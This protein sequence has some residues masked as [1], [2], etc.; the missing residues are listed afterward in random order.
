MSALKHVLSVWILCFSISLGASAQSAVTVVSTADYGPLIAP[1][2]IASVFGANLANTHAAAVLDASGNLPTSIGGTSVSVNGEPA[3]LFYVSP[4]Q[5]NFAV[6]ADVPTGSATVTITSPSLSSPVS[7]GAQV[8]LA[9]PGIFTIVC[10]RTDRGLSRTRL[11][12]ASS[13]FRLQQRKIRA[14]TRALG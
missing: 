6:P 11:P 7:G 13:R 2:S 9:A 14:A 8:Q 4:G 10:L 1:G 3:G 12:E 5:V